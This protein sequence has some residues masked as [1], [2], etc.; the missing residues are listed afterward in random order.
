L[1]AI[2]LHRCSHFDRIDNL[3]VSGTS[4]EIAFDGTLDFITRRLWVFI[5]ECATNDEESRGTEA[6]LTSTGFGEA[7]LNWM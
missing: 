6:T 7:P 5:E 2:S 1:A 3:L 4:A